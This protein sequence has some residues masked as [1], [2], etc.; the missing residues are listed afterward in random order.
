[1]SGSRWHPFRPRNVAAI[2][3]VAVVLL[4]AKDLFF[5]VGLRRQPEPTVVVLAPGGNLDDIARELAARGLIKSPFAFGLLARITGV[6]RNL[7]A[8]Q[9]R[10][11]RG[12]SVLSILRKLAR[13]MSGEDLVTIP[14]GLT[15]RDIARLLEVRLGVPPDSFLTACADP[16]LLR[17]LEVPAPNP[18]GYLFP[19]SY[20]FLPGTPPA[21]ILRR[22]VGETRRVLAEELA[23]GSPVAHE[24]TPHEILTLAS[25]VEAEAARPEERERIAAVYLNRLRKG[26][27]LQA[28]P[29]VAYALGGYR[30]RL[31]YD[32]LKVESP[33][34]TYR[35][36][37]LPPGPIGNP[38]RASIHA[39]L[40]PLPGS[41]ELFFVARGD[42]THVF[43]ETGEAHEAARLAI[44][45][46]RAAA[47]DSGAATDSTAAVLH[48][49]AQRA[50][51]GPPSGEKRSP[52]AAAVV[53]PGAADTGAMGRRREP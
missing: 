16:A 37:G 26:M 11:Y 8:G 47:A 20:A 51:L 40:S 12:E 1:V 38:G 42:G 32:D 23:A 13:G 43:S 39:V 3:A 46:A 27:R 29:T 19:S 28:D 17:E 21:A 35:N 36:L 6:D 53:P 24:L 14:E 48:L 15:M 5:P 30:E 34:N 25:I 4:V 18:E 41:R 31:Y 52:A 9:Y 10:I 2:L 49:P 22:M 50:G 45:A 33:Y 7:K 44:R